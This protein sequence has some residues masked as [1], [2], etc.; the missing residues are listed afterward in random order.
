MKNRWKITLAAVTVVTALAFTIWVEAT[1]FEPVTEPG[2]L[3]RAV[4]VHCNPTRSGSFEGKALEDAVT[5]R[6]LAAQES[7]ALSTKRLVWLSWLQVFVAVGG[8][9]TV[10]WTVL[11]A[12]RSMELTRKTLTH[13]QTIDRLQLRPKFERQK[14]KPQI[15]ADGSAIILL[16]FRNVGLTAAR[17]VRKG[18]LHSIAR[19]ID[20]KSVLKPDKLELPTEGGNLAA[21]GS[22][23]W[24]LN[25]S[26]N[27]V[28]RVLAGTHSW[29]VV[30][31]IIF[32]DELGG[33]YRWSFRKAFFG[34]DL[35]RERM[36]TGFKWTHPDYKGR[37]L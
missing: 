37:H 14:L 6:D 19:G 26:A 16:D 18:L 17:Q 11:V 28:K 2:T 33:R 21:G 5:C 9:A 15:L 10:L 4:A 22:V 36:L 27:D 24:S 13:Q 3:A 7:M 20:G 30:A 29:Q 31:V 32:D 35:M 23:A 34:N 25:L 1:P 8:A 12:L